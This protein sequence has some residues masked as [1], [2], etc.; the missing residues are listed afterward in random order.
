M[1]KIKKEFKLALPRFTLLVKQGEQTE[2]LVEP[3][4]QAQFTIANEE[5]QEDLDILTEELLLEITDLKEENFK[6][7]SSPDFM[8]IR[9]L[10]NEWASVSSNVIYPD[11][12][13]ATKDRIPLAMPIKRDDGSELKAIELTIPTVL[14][15]RL[16]RKKAAHQQNSFITHACTGLTEAEQGRLFMPDWTQ[17]QLAVSDFLNKKADYFQIKTSTP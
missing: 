1:S 17:V 10:I 16:A 2:L 11:L 9:T 3:L 15:R 6:N 14:T 12:E 8:S 13:K 4:T 7:L 5:A